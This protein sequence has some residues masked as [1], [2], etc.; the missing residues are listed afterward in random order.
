MKRISLFVV[1]VVTIG[2]FVYQFTVTSP[3]EAQ[4]GSSTRGGARRGGESLGGNQTR[5]VPSTFE[6]RFWNWLQSVQY[7]NWAP[8][9]GQNGGSYAGKS[10]HGA[11]LKMYLNRIAVGNAQTLPHGSVIIK[12]NF[13]KDQKTLMAVT[14]MYRSKD[15]KGQGYDP[16]N[17]DWYWV[18]YNPD[19]SVATKGNMRLAGRLK[20]CI[21]CHSG[22]DGDDY[23]FFNDA[24]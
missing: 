22:A 12:E 20:G 5:R 3:A 11:F 13:G 18:K 7:H 4:S 8:A 15:R 23:V 2:A 14:V 17:N 9:P 6:G 1:T 21:E 19:G 10:P 24:N 16:D